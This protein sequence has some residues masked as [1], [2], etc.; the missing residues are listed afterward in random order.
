MLKALDFV[1]PKTGDDGNEYIPALPDVI[2]TFQTF[3]GRLHKFA[4]DEF[5]RR[6]QELKRKRRVSDRRTEDKSVMEY[7]PIT[8]EDLTKGRELIQILVRMIKM[9]DLRKHAHCELLEGYLCATLDHVGSSLSLLTFTDTDI[10]RP[11]QTGLLP[12]NGLLDIGQ[13]NIES[14][15]GTATIEGP[16]VL[17]V[18]RQ[19]LEFLFANTGRMSKKNLFNFTLHPQADK[20]VTGS[21]DLR[22]H[23][24]DTLQNTLLRGAFGDEDDTFYNSLRRDEENDEEVDLNNTIGEIRQKESSAEWFIGELWEHLGWDIL[25]GRRGV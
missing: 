24:Q 1:Q 21:N 14:A 23:I 20:G 18:L 19:G 2:R 17:F 22:Q 3:L 11:E 6:E 8:E 7:T 25:S 16:Y 9:L 12:P 15:T 13:L 4:L 5:A 10:S